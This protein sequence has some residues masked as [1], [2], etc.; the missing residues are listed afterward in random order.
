MILHI[1]KK[2]LRLLW[3]IVV[4]VAA[5]QMTFTLMLIHI[6]QSTTSKK[7]LMGCYFNSSCSWHFLG[8]LF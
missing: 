1:M 6:D 2:D 7:S 5:V 8:A 3:K 4:L